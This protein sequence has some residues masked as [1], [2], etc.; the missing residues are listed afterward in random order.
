MKKVHDCNFSP[1]WNF[2]GDFITRI[3]QSM[4]ST[5]LVYTI[6]CY[7]FHI[8]LLDIPNNPQIEKVTNIPLAS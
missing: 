4:K 7:S 2:Y 5:Y 8:F 6:F 1:H 3:N